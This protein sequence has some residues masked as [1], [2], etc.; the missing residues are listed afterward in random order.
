MS[1]PG[2]ARELAELA[3]RRET[4]T[5]GALAA[6]L[7]LDGPGRIARLTGALEDLMEEDAAQGA[8]LRAALV[9]GRASGHLPARGFFDKARELGLFDGDDPARFHGAHLAALHGRALRD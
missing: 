2:L 1:L 8:A 5:Y 4:V 6:R 7:G 3:A 9:L